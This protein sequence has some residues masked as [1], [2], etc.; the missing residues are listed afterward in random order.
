MIVIDA[1]ILGAL[2]LKDETFHIQA[3][4]QFA[5]WSRDSESLVAPRLILAEITALIRKAVFLKRITHEEGVAILDTILD[6]DIALYESP[7]IYT[8]ALNVAHLLNHPRT[9]DAQYLA[10]AQILDCEVWTLDARLYNSARSH[11]PR[12]RMLEHAA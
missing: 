3:V 2:V 5:S 11:F 9:Y 1:S 4:D 8:S 10:L 7:S 6:A 12:L